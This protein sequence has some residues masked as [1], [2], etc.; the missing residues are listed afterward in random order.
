MSMRVT[1][2]ELYEKHAA[3]LTRFATTLVG[4]GQAEDVVAEAVLRSMASP[5]WPSVAE[6]RAYLFRAVHNQAKMLRRSELRRSLRETRSFE[7][8]DS[9]VSERWLEVRDAMERLSV[10]ERGVLYL[11]YWLDLPV[12]EI[13]TTLQLSRRTTMRALRSARTTLEE[14]LS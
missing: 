1:D 14:T 12:D 5:S 7:R 2:A 10:R 13:A 8:V 3:E 11:A 9:P 4:P 6:P